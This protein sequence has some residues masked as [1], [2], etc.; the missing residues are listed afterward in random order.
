[1]GMR[2]MKLKSSGKFAAVFL[3]GAV[4]AGGVGAVASHKTH[5]PSPHVQISA[6]EHS[7]YR[8]Q[9]PVLPIAP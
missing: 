5:L 8:Q 6:Q 1:M 9:E 2:Q 3:A 4:I 7:S